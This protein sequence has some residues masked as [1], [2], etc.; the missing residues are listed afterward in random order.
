MGQNIKH[1]V[2]WSLILLLMVTGAHAQSERTHMNIESALGDDIPA[3]FSKPIGNLDGQKYPACLVLHGSGGLFKEN[4]PG[5]V[6]SNELEQNFDQIF[7][8][9]EALGVVV[10]AP[11]SFGRSAFF[12]EDNEAAFMPFAP[13]PF[14]N[15]GDGQP[16]RD[17]AYKSRRVLTRVLDA[18]GALAFLANQPFVDSGNLCVIGTS[19]GGTTAMA[20]AANGIA[21]H[22][23]EFVDTE[24]QRPFESQSDFLERQNTFQHYPPLLAGLEDQLLELPVLKFS[25]AIAPGC[26]MRGLIP[27]VH[28]DGIDIMSHPDDV[29][30]ANDGFDELVATSQFVEMGSLDSVPDHCRMG[31]IRYLQANAFEATF[32]IDPSRFVTQEY[33]GIGHDLV[34]DYPSILDRTHEL[35]VDHFYLIHRNSFE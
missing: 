15:P 2:C 30:Y 9:L 21:R 10:I 1:W 17:D 29:Y 26:F 33:P 23:T 19:N 6:C 24:H 3:Y 28:P 27:T 13:P 25:Q 5:Q 12:C 4:E 14:F 34:R 31:G 16:V 35:T 22:V 11:D 7:A 18:F 8:V 32:D 20:M